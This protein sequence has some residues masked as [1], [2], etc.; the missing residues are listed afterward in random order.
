MRFVVYCLGAVWFS[1]TCWQIKNT[2]V[3]TKIPP[4]FSTS[5]VKE[6]SVPGDLL[7]CRCSIAS[8]TSLNLKFSVRKGKSVLDGAGGL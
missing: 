7:S 2:C 8:L 3:F 5:A 4:R 6:L 1:Y